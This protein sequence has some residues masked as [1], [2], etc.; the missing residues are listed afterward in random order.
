[1]LVIRFVDRAVRQSGALAP[2]G[3]QQARDGGHSSFRGPPEDAHRAQISNF[4]PPQHAWR[5]PNANRSSS[6][7]HLPCRSQP[8]PLRGLGAESDVE[9]GLAD[10]HAVQNARELPR[11]SRDRK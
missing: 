3:R 10:T 2:E 1:M 4:V 5:K 8:K 11:P 7:S 6:A 9:V